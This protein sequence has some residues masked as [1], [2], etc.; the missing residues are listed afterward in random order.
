MR[1]PHLLVGLFGLAACVVLTAWASAQDRTR[2]A[3]PKA[4]HTQHQQHYWDCAKACDDCG[5]MCDACGAHCVQLVADG[6]KDHLEIARTCQDCASVCVAAGCITA[7]SGPFSESICNACADAC[8]RCGDAC[9]KHKD[10]PM[11]K[12]CANECRKCEQACRDMV[13]HIGTGTERR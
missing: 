12:N 7:R 13:K 3:D 8:K 9:D 2:T 1:S 5:R 6:H 10:D 4:V 11:M